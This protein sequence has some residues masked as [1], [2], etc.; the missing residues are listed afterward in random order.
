MTR[1]SR[2]YLLIYSH[3]HCVLIALTL[4]RV[5]ELPVHSVTVIEFHPLHCRLSRT[6]NKTE[7][8]AEWNDLISEFILI[9]LVKNIV[10]KI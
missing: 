8:V 7:D 1:T 5:S 9:V 2:P 6:I 4:V 10:N 3:S